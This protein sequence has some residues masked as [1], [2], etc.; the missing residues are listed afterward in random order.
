MQVVIKPRKIKAIGSPRTRK[1]Q[2][3]GH[4]E[5]SRPQIPGI[6]IGHYLVI[7]ADHYV[8][9]PNSRRG[10]VIFTVKEARRKMKSAGIDYDN[11]KEGSISKCYAVM[12]RRSMGNEDKIAKALN[13]QTWRP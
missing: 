8:A 6:K 3:Y 13:P 10:W 12:H 9:A 1:N 2:P 4:L 11:C 5:L 7:D